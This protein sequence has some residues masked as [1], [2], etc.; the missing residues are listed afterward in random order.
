MPP[1]LASGEMRKKGTAEVTTLMVFCACENK[2]RAKTNVP[3][4]RLLTILFMVQ[5]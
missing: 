3:A 5:F 1:A 4:N 2:G